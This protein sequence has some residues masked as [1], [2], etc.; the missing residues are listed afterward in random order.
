MNVGS[1]IISDGSLTVCIKCIMCTFLWLLL[2]YI[3][4]IE[5]NISY[6]DEYFKNLLALMRNIH[7]GWMTLNEPVSFKKSVE[8]VIP[9]KKFVESVSPRICF[10]KSVE[11]PWMNL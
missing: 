2:S 4:A 8:P 5:M 7:T 1:V 6:W 11:G 10:K 9:F 3:F